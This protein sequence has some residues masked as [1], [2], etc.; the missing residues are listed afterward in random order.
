MLHEEE[1]L[2]LNTYNETT[3]IILVNINKGKLLKCRH[4]L[5]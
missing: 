4:I 3:N 1:L 2:L 5:I